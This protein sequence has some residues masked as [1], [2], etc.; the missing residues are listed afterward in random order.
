MRWQLESAALK[1]SHIG[2]FPLFCPNPGKFCSLKRDASPLQGCCG[3]A[4][5]A[6]FRLAAD[7]LSNGIPLNY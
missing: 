3:I 1:K 6:A 7:Y 2:P 4:T 5:L